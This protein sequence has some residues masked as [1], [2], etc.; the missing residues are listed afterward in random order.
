MMIDSEPLPKLIKFIQNEL[1]GNSSVTISQDDD[2]LGGGHIDSMGIMR[3]IAYLE[4]E[5]GISVPP[6]DVTIENFESPRTIATYVQTALNQ[7]S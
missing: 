1:M 2:L 3:L 4:S 7:R 5:F 6:E